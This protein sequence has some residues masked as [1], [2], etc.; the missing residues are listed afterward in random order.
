ML[1]ITACLPDADDAVRPVG[2]R[3]R[4]ISEHRTRGVGPRAAVGVGQHG[5][6]L[7]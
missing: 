4:Q 5:G 3:G 7:R 2:D 6:D 1:T